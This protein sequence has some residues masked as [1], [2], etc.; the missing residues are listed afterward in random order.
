MPMSLAMGTSYR[1][2]GQKHPSVLG[3]IRQEGVFGTHLLS[4]V[5][6]ISTPLF[7]GGPNIVTCPHQQHPFEAAWEALGRRRPGW[8][9]GPLPSMPLNPT[10]SHN[11]LPMCL[12]SA[13]C[14]CLA[15]LFIV[16]LW[17]SILTEFLIGSHSSYDTVVGRGR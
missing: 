8:S 17:L 12:V 10:S 11:C 16:K 14:L 6:T 7:Q 15:P 13:F 3:Q 9:L 1:S 5:P 2:G 4:W